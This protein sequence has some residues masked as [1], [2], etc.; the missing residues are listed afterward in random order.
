V[1][2]LSENPTVEVRIGVPIYRQE[3]QG[4]TPKTDRVEVGPTNTHGTIINFRP[5]PEIFE[6]LDFKFETLAQRMREM[7]CLTRGRKITLEDRR[8]GQETQ[9]T[10]HYEGGLKLIMVPWVL[11]GP[12]STRSVLGVPL[13]YSC[14]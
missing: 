4:G 13:W 10:Y 11:V 2:S 12:T 3:Y 1:K 7:A 5:D 6:D 9:E 14:R 8:K